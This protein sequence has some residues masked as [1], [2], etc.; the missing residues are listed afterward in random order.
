MSPTAV[1]HRYGDPP[2][3]KGVDNSPMN[4]FAGRM[5]HLPSV[6]LRVEL[7]RISD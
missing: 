3:L 7:T 5:L 6:N 1:R 2:P 4:D